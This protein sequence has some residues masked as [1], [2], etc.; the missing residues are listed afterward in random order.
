MEIIISYTI[1]HRIMKAFWENA[2]G[3]I[4]SIMFPMNTIFK[5]YF[6]SLIICLNHKAYYISQNN[7]AFN[8]IIQIQRRHNKFKTIT[9]ISLHIPSRKFLMKPI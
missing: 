4:K 7:M 1:G 2:N 8:Y 3:Y 5:E 6:S 9:T